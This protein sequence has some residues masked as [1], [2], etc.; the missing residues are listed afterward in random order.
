MAPQRTVKMYPKPFGKYSDV[1][2]LF[3]YSS[4]QEFML[5]F[6][7]TVTIPNDKVFHFYNVVIILL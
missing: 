5:D 2:L 1:N 3:H 6:D 4:S 7:R